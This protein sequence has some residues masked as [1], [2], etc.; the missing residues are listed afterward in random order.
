MREIS[1][2]HLYP[3]LITFEANVRRRAGKIMPKKI[4][5]T[6]ITKT[7]NISLKGDSQQREA[8]RERKM[9][10]KTACF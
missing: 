7:L 6:E 9:W 2:Y 3:W 5:M 10:E 8:Q 4:K 1:A